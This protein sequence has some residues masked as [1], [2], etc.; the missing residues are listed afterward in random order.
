[1]MYLNNFCI[2]IT[3]F[4]FFMLLDALTREF[5]IS[6]ANILMN[7]LLSD[8]QEMKLKEMLGFKDAI[9]LA[10]FHGWDLFMMIFIKW[11]KANSDLMN[12]KQELGNII[13]E[14][15]DMQ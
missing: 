4:N 8:E 5:I 9:D 12:P 6:R 7:K 15:L 3:P 13:Q 1:M 11:G 2:C 14:V 10:D